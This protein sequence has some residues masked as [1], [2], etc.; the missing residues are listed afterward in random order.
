MIGYIVEKHFEYVANHFPRNNGG[1][2]RTAL[3]ASAEAAALHSRHLAE[4][5]IRLQNELYWKRVKDMALTLAGHA[6]GM[7]LT[8]SITTALQTRFRRS[9]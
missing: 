3:M 4:K 1:E 6:L 5:R 2:G 8:W 9:R 7:L